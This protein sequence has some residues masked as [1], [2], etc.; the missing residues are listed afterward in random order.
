VAFDPVVDAG[1]AVGGRVR[2]ERMIVRFAF[3]EQ[4]VFLRWRALK[5]K[6]EVPLFP[7]PSLADC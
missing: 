3:E 2:R 7:K 6:A 1:N 5:L 4:T